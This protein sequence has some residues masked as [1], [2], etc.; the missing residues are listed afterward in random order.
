MIFQLKK[1][2]KCSLYYYN[3]HHHYH[4]SHHHHCRHRRCHLYHYHMG[5]RCN[6]LRENCVSVRLIKDNP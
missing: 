5:T 1:S 6:D 3:Y 4:H 2:S